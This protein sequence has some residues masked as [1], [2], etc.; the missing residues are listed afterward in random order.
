MAYNPY[1]YRDN[2][3]GVVGKTLK[4]PYR[5]GR[6]ALRTLPTWAPNAAAGLVARKTANV[7][8][9]AASKVSEIDRLRAAA[10]TAY[11][12]QSARVMRTF[13][14]R[15]NAAADKVRVAEAAL[16]QRLP[17]L[18]QG[19]T[20]A[21]EDVR[22]ARKLVAESPTGSTVNKARNT[23]IARTKRKL[24]S[25]FAAE[26][27]QLASTPVNGP[28]DLAARAKVIKTHR[29]AVSDAVQRVSSQFPSRAQASKSA[30]IAESM[31]DDALKA[32]QA[33]A[34]A[35]RT[36]GNQ[37]RGAVTAAKEAYQATGEQ[38]ARYAGLAANRAKVAVMR[39]APTL[40]KAETVL[41]G[42]GNRL[43]AVPGAVKSAVGTAADM[44]KNVLRAVNPL[45]SKE[46]VSAALGKSGT[47]LTGGAKTAKAIGN[48]ALVKPAGGVAK[49]G[50]FIAG[51]P[52]KGIAGA[53]NTIEK[54]GQIA[55]AGNTGKAAKLIRGAT[56][57][58][59]LAGAFAFQAWSDAA[60]EAYKFYAEGGKLSDVGKQKIETINGKQVAMRN[61]GW[62]D[63]IFSRDFAKGILKGTQSALTLGLTGKGDDTFFDHVFE[64]DPEEANKRLNAQLDPAQLRDIHGNSVYTAEQLNKMQTALASAAART[65]MEQDFVK[66]ATGTL[67][68]QNFRKM[69]GDITAEKAATMQKMEDNIAN[70]SEFSKTLR[71]GVKTEDGYR[72]AVIA[73]A[74][75]TYERRMKML[76]GN[77]AA[78]D[79]MDE[80]RRAAYA[81]SGV[82]GSGDYDADVKNA[83]HASDLREFNKMWNDLS[84]ADRVS[85]NKED[86][87]RAVAEAEAEYEKANPSKPAEEEAA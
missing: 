21:T 16:R 9:S 41:H 73:N 57:A 53:F 38:A 85:W 76:L 23:A 15:V 68:V 47:V 34:D 61:P 24:E 12:R 67:D 14:P 74:E 54:V 22:L 81:H 28:A 5:L 3:E 64:E 48:W 17:T 46:A 2:R 33:A 80:N 1:E 65:K 31:L 60:E 63:I 70:F 43:Q 30:R 10:Q 26:A 72:Q 45:G 69:L 79:V 44:A 8:R 27:R 71:G 29:R 86:A 82:F 37:L 56:S 6:G 58:S 4:A 66:R 32:Q 39:R 36:G 62:S 35:L 25:K 11:E 75:K 42:V 84:D 52:V 18:R 83:A 59:S 13:A 77:K 50:K 19:L 87:D 40:T 7:Y 78:K 49:V 20:S 51:A 55:T